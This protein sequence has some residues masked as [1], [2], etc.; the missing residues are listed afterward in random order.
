MAY[1][2]LRFAKLKI[3]VLADPLETGFNSI[4]YAI[5]CMTVANALDRYSDRIRDPPGYV[6]GHHK[7]PSRCTQVVKL[8]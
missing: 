5:P 2:N 3:R 7:I 1:K 6:I 8:N 4:R